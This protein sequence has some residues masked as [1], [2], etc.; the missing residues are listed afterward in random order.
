M[1]M[2]KSND[3]LTKALKLPPVDVLDVLE[4]LVVNGEVGALAR[5]TP[6][7][8]FLMVELRVKRLRTAVIIHDMNE[9]SSQGSVLSWSRQSKNGV[10]NLD[11]ER[12]KVGDALYHAQSITKDHDIGVLQNS[13]FNTSKSS[14]ELL[15]AEK[16]DLQIV[17]SF[18]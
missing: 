11:F 1:L 12:K 13:K 15:Q 6:N 8:A 5:K 7:V 14:Y 17:V 2:R 18:T 9:A 10:L 4:S 16:F 3:G